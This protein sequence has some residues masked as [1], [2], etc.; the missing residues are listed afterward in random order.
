[1]EKLSRI[2]LTGETPFH[3]HFTL[4]NTHSDDEVFFS[5]RGMG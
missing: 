5:E 3:H 1:M 2:E 4:I